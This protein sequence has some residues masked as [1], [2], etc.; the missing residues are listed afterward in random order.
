MNVASRLA[1]LERKAAEAGL[2][3]CRHCLWGFL[4]IDRADQAGASDGRHGYSPV[5]IREWMA[6]DSDGPGRRMREPL[7]D[8]DKARVVGW[9]DDDTWNP[10]DLR[11]RWCGGKVS[12]TIIHQPLPL[13]EPEERYAD[14]LSPVSGSG[15][16]PNVRQGNSL[17]PERGG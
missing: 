6:R 9:T 11:C 7:S 10:E 2:G 13:E 4:R 17:C 12:V 16:L 15:L 1:R 8:E 5:V 3:E 14:N